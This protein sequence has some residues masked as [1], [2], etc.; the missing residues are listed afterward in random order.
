LGL[1]ICQSLVQAMGGRIWL[2]SVLQNGTSFYFTVRLGVPDSKVGEYV[3][4]MN[5]AGSV[6]VRFRQIESTNT[7]S[8]YRTRLVHSVHLMC[9][10]CMASDRCEGQRYCWSDGHR[11]SGRGQPRSA[12]LTC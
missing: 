4:W 6:C 9:R 5:L 2:Q 3:T 1:C 11:G 10:L 12:S 7:K 8:D